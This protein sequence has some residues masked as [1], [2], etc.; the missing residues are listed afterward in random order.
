MK[1]SILITGASGNLGKAAIDRFLSEGYRILATSSPGKTL[2]YETD[3]VV[4]YEADL[5]SEKS[6][7]QTVAQMINDHQQIDAALLLV[8][9]YAA[10]TIIET[11]D[12]SL[13]KMFA[14]NFD[15]AYYVSRQ[16]FKQ[17]ISQPTGGRIV[18]VGSRPAIVPEEGKNNVAYALSKSLIF[19]LA[20]IL[21]AEGKNRN[22]VSSVIVPGTI[23]TPA[24]RKANP[25]ANFSD[26]VTPEEV[27]EAMA[28]LVSEKGRALRDP[29]LKLYS[30]L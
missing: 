19:T 7:E 26:W 15:T 27:G 2:G 6:V 14:L 23:D 4:T 20:D 28:F 13:K 16:V 3:D 30:N 11:D 10:G 18:F 24:N 5:T 17:M 12:A 8:G 25:S 22:V 21:N 29:I 9:A 1:K